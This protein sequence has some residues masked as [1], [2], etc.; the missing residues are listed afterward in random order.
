MSGEPVNP[1][2]EAVA[3]G[4]DVGST[5]VKAVVVDPVTKE[6]LWS[7]YQRHQTKQPEK[8]LEL[9]ERIAAAFP[10]LRQRPDPHLHHRLGRRPLGPHSGRSSSRRSTRSRWRSRP[11]PRRRLGHRARR[12]GREDHHLQG[13]RGDRR[14]DRHRLDERQVRV[15]HRRHHRQVHDQGRHAHRGGRASS[16]F[17]DS[18]L[19]HVAAKCGV[20]AETD[21]VNLVKTGIPSNEILCSLADAIVMQNLSV[22]TRGNTLQPQGAAARRPEHL[23]AVPPGVLAPAHP[24]DLGRAR[25][26][27]PEG[28]AD[29]GADLRPRERA[30]LRGASAPSIYG[31]HEAAE[32]GVYSGLDRAQRVHHQRPQGAPRRD[33]RARR[34]SQDRGSE[35]DD[36]PRAL[37]DPRSSSPRRSSRARWSRPSSASTAARPRRRPCSS[38]RGRASSLKKPYQLSKG[39]P[40]QDTKELLARAQDVRHRP[41][42]DARGDRLRRDRLRRRRARGVACKPTSTSSRPSPT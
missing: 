1:R 6:I 31:L 24:R 28:R 12:P 4:I 37:H 29:R 14:Q 11:A 16:H 32:V 34:S 3:I 39:N 42:R 8:V 22:L 7:D 20:F 17:D 21:I 23:P 5:T 33:R 9:L 35:L 19:H 13:G 36:V 40:I 10:N 2:T 18:K 15:G 38:T 27:L 30:V 25:L 26:R 41:G